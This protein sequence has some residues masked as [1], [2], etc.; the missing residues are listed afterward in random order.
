MDEAEKKRAPASRRPQESWRSAAE[1]LGHPSAAPWTS[2]LWRR[3]AR[4]GATSRPAFNCSATGRH[5][6]SAAPG[7]PP[8]GPKRGPKRLCSSQRGTRTKQSLKAPQHRSETHG[9]SLFGC[10][11]NER[12][13]FQHPRSSPKA[14]LSPD[15]QSQRLPGCLATP[16]RCFWTTSAPRLGW[17]KKGKGSCGHDFARPAADVRCGARKH[18]VEKAPRR[19]AHAE[20]PRAGRLERLRS[21]ACF[22]AQKGRLSAG[23]V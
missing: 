12:L 23:R 16:S 4:H 14:P 8:R 22:R 11:C 21:A 1:R 17:A 9:S 10:H 2:T 18:C 20:S 3:A 13:G 19:S 6:D 15:L 7:R 5:G